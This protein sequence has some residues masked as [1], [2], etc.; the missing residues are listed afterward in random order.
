MAMPTIR[1]QWLRAPWLGH[2]AEIGTL[3][4][5]A[6][7]KAGG[8]E[9]A[10]AR[11]AP[12]AR[13][14]SLHRRYHPLLSNWSW[15]ATRQACRI[16]FHHHR[17]PRYQLAIPLE[18]FQGWF[19]PVLGLPSAPLFICLEMIKGFPQ[20]NVLRALSHC[21]AAA[22]SLR[23]F[24]LDAFLLG[25]RH[26]QFAADPL[27]RLHLSLHCPGAILIFPFSNTHAFR[28]P[29][30][31]RTC[32]RLHARTFAIIHATCRSLHA[33]SAWLSMGTGLLWHQSFVA[34]E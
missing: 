11:M 5:P 19:R 34:A 32:R 3:T 7:E 25:L 30:R 14:S 31:N 23:P 24:G 17:G 16:S 12:P 20:F 26:S 18:S 15:Y 21:T 29:S 8:C 9:A 22:R 27:G 10:G 28:K 2:G 33:F 1:S 13:S 6:R 4:K